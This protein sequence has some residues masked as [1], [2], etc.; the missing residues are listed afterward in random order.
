MKQA[1]FI[2]AFFRCLN[3]S[4]LDEETAWDSPMNKLRYKDNINQDISVS[5]NRNT[6]IV[7]L[8]KITKSDGRESSTIFIG[9]FDEYLLLPKHQV[10]LRDFRLSLLV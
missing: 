8:I 3:Y 2:I 10:E 1:D 5:F 7:S 9:S 4:F 6:D